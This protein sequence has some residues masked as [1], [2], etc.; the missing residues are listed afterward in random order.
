[1]FLGGLY[2]RRIMTMSG[3]EAWIAVLR[4]AAFPQDS[5]GISMN[6]VVRC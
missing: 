6:L 1:M 4:G 5:I 2:R 3:A